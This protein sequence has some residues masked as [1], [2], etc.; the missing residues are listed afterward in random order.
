MF[1]GA[2]GRNSPQGSPVWLLSKDPCP[3]GPGKQALSLS[4]AWHV[5]LSPCPPGTQG[6]MGAGDRMCEVLCTSWEVLCSSCPCLW[7]CYYLEVGTTGV[8]MIGWPLSGDIH[9]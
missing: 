2:E 5:L 7:W 4:S 6:S 9:P 8:V 3:S 1:I